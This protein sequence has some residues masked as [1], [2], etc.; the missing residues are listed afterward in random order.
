VL[1][2]GPRITKEKTVDGH[3]ACVSYNFPNYIVITTL[4]NITCLTVHAYG[5]NYWNERRL[6]EF[7][8]LN[9][10]VYKNLRG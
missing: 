8:C 4:N 7:L 10:G 9:G 2:S 3:V 5:Y 1:V 6:F